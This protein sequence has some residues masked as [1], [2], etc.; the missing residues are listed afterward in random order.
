MANKD[1]INLKENRN[2][3]IDCYKSIGGEKIRKF[4]KTHSLIAAYKNKHFS[5]YEVSSHEFEEDDV[6]VLIENRNG[7]KFKKFWDVFKKE[8]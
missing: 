3:E 2:G 4:Y 1:F 5:I 7:R 8:K 6:Y